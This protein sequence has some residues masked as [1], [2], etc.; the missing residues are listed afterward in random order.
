M[1]R[2]WGWASA[3]AALVMVGCGGGSGNVQDSVVAP[4]P[5]LAGSPLMQAL[6]QRT[7]DSSAGPQSGSGAGKASPKILAQMAVGQPQNLL[8]VLDD[9]A[10]QSEAEG[11]QRQLGVRPSHQAILDLKSQR[12]SEAK[13]RLLAPTRAVEVSEL[14]S[15]SHLPILSLRVRSKNAL[16]KLLADPAVVGVYEDA[17]MHRA[18]LAQSLPLIGQPQ[19]AAAGDQGAGTTVVVLDQRV[20]YTLPAFGSCAA[21][22]AAGCKVLLAQDV[23]GLPNDGLGYQDGHGTNVAA[24]VLAVAPGAKIISL[25]VFNGGSALE[26]DV[27]AGINF[28]I[29]N[30]SAYHIV[31]M[32]L[33]LG[34]ASSTIATAASSYFSAFANA[35][36]AGILPVVAAGNNGYTNALSIPGAVLGAVSVGAVYDSSYGSKTWTTA[37]CT[38]ASTKADQVACFSNSASFLTLLAPGCEDDAA[39]VSAYFCGTSQATP[40]VAGAVAVLRSAFPAESLTQ[41]VTRLTSGAQVTDPKNGITKPR[42]SLPLALSLASCTTSVSVATTS[43][44]EYGTASA[45]IPVSTQNGC[46]W[47]ATSDVSWITIL[48]GSPGTGSGSV[49]YFVAPN[50]GAFSRSGTMTIAGQTVTVVEPGGAVS[51]NL[52]SDVSLVGSDSYQTSG[53]SSAALTAGSIFNASTTRTTGTLR[54]ELWVGTG[55]FTPGA[56]GTRLATWQ[57]SGTSNGTLGPR[58][59]FTNL[60]SQ[61]LPI[62]ALPPPGSYYAYLLLTEYFGSTATC[63]ADHFCLDS[64]A[65]FNSAFIVPD[66]TAPTV[67]TGLAVSV[68]SATQLQLNWN[69]STDDAAV[70]AYNIY[71]SGLLLGSAATNSALAS[72]LLPSSTH[73][74]TVS[75]CDATGNCSAQSQAAS[76]A[77]PASVLPADCLFNWAEQ[78]YPQFFSPAGVT[79]ATSSPYYYRYYRSTNTYLGLSSTD[80]DIWVKGPLSGNT[81]FD[82]GAS[83]IYLNTSACPH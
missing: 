14:K 75:A 54:L 10:I 8:V 13:G 24:T 18:M 78:T 31:A 41:T 23:A 65:N 36:A 29:A 26:S 22:G 55:P 62:V 70:T 35:R 5:Q 6:A 52:Q 39:L 37:S 16:D 72:N 76:G 71:S 73:Q 11:L 80:G 28:A 83:S 19:A 77:T 68:R 42:L 9:S 17:V 56:S 49:Q 30:V 7:Q 59:S 4:A 2:L 45:S 67:P 58:Q 63:A 53:L 66:V 48:S 64:F 57:L 61:P 34:G 81:L 44:S 21:P 43:T 60:V 3:L 51:P 46:P 74:Y 12:M 20:N 25:N 40:H 15:Y 32:N 38:D 27:V 47:I 79:S 50:Y 1:T 33:S 69:P 82:V